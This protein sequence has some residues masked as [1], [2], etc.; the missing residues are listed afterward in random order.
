MTH[1]F[2]FLGITCSLFSLFFTLV[3]LKQVG[4]TVGWGFQLQSPSMIICLMILFTILLLSTLDILIIRPPSFIQNKKASNMFWSG[5][6]TTIIA[7]PCTA[8]FLGTALSVALFQSIFTGSLIFLMISIG[9]ALP[10]IALIVSPKAASLIPTSG[11]WN[12]HI[13][14]ILSIGFC[15]TLLWLTWVLSSQ[16][17]EFYFFSCLVIIMASTIWYLIKKFKSIQQKSLHLA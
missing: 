5:I 9:L 11:K 16:L 7:T 12:Q 2:T 4:H 8:P 1:C 17:S 6:L 13:K 15:I 14:T 10:M 3:A